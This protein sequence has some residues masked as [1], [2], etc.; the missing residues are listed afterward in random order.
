MRRRLLLSLIAALALPL[1]G[2]GKSSE[3]VLKAD[4]E[5]IYVE[6]DELK[7]QVQSSRQL[8]QLTLDDRPY[9]Q[10]I[11]PAQARLGPDEEWFGVFMRVENE[12][13]ETHP[14]AVDFEIHDTQ[15]NVYT[16]ID[17][18]Q[19]LDRNYF[20]Y[21]AQEVGPGTILPIADSP[22]GERQPYGSLILFKVRRFSLDNRPLELIIKGRGRPATEAVVDIDV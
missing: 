16:P 11:A 7:Y 6:V 20:V 13:G 22:A 8:N 21:Q 10:G 3:P 17:F 12:T 18:V 5:G 9:L 1:V 4:T 19:P 2:C 14:S 15:E